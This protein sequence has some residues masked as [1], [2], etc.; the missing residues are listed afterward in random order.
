[1][2]HSRKGKRRGHPSDAD[3]G[4]TERQQR[5]C[6][7]LRLPV[8]DQASE[9]VRYM[10]RTFSY[11]LTRTREEA[12]D[13]ARQKRAELLR[14]PEVAAALGK[15][16]GD[17]QDR[18]TVCRPGGHRGKGALSSLRGVWV[19]VD[20]LGRAS[21]VMRLVIGRGL[22]PVARS[23]S[24]GKYSVEG[25]VR[26]AASHAGRV[27]GSEYSDTEVNLA[28]EQAK[29]YLASLSRRRKQ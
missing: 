8:L 14:D 23:W 20:A 7:V 2:L 29:A 13:A 3:Y 16:Y 28:V 25:A 9:R 15:L 4:L 26:H 24:I 19:S 1:M 18:S 27:L 22:P 21:V 5:R 11:G 17:P 10:E 6:I 12:L